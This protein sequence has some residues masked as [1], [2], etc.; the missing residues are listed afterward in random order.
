MKLFDVYY[1]G[2]VPGT[3]RVWKENLSVTKNYHNVTLRKN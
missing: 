3:Y 2:V 1:N